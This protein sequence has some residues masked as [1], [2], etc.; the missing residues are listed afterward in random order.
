MTTDLQLGAKIPKSLLDALS[1]L[2]EQP[3]VNIPD[4][5]FRTLYVRQER[6]LIGARRSGKT[7]CTAVA[8]GPL[9]PEAATSAPYLGIID[10][11]GDAS[12]TFKKIAAANKFQKAQQAFAPNYR[13]T[14][15]VRD[16]T[17]PSLDGRLKYLG[18]VIGQFGFVAR[19]Y[20]KWLPPEAESILGDTWLNWFVDARQRFMPELAY[21]AALQL[22]KF[23]GH[24]F[25]AKREA[26]GAWVRAQKDLCAPLVYMA[27]E[28]T[29][30]WVKP[31]PLITPRERA[32]GRI[33]NYNRAINKSGNGDRIMDDFCDHAENV[34][35]WRVKHG[36]KYTWAA[37]YA[38]GST[39]VKRVLTSHKLVE[40]L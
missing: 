36:G 32:L 31:R 6:I 11:D 27:P 2:P 26:C 15:F 12:A 21:A 33:S 9:F 8:S 35:V 28:D 24:V 34:G 30:F 7:T 39:Y 19:N 10:D 18:A 22:P 38:L 1:T 23:D 3:A 20:W 25:N 16:S 17:W 29:Y 14:A 37:P 13:W 40:M 5:F 4:D